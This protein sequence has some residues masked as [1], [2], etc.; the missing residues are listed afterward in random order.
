MGKSTS[1]TQ[2][3]MKTPLVQSIDL[4]VSTIIQSLASHHFC[5][6]FCHMIVLLQS[7][8]Q[9]SKLQLLLEQINSSICIPMGPSSACILFIVFFQ[10]SNHDWI[11]FY[12]LHS[13]RIRIIMQLI[14]Y[15]ENNFLNRI[16]NLDNYVNK[17]KKCNS[18]TLYSR[19]PFVCSI[20]SF[21]SSRTTAALPRLCDV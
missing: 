4:M 10:L 9:Q 19:L 6:P 17:C 1:A 3:N 21:S 5:K 14:I 20:E 11:L 13:S 2:R 8:Y 15:I 7:C 18:I 12:H 16:F